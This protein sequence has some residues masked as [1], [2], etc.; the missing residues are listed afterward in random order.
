[1]T[2]TLSPSMVAA[3]I[4]EA[5]DQQGV[6]PSWLASQV[7]VIAKLGLDPALVTQATVARANRLFRQAIDLVTAPYVKP[8]PQV[9]P[10]T[11][12]ALT[13]AVDTPTAEASGGRKVF[14][15]PKLFGKY[16]LTAV[17]RR[18]SKEGWCKEDIWFFLGQEEVGGNGMSEATVRTQMQWGKAGHGGPPAPLDTKELAWCHK[19][20]K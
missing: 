2:A 17:V 13:P 11:D 19:L 4:A 5:A 6:T 3:L 1:M 9:Q 15:G 20:L 8:A 16:S 12:V 14:R 10:A 7:D 18:L